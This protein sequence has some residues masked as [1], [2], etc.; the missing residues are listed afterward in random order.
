MA[1]SSARAASPK[2]WTNIGAP[3][4]VA[5]PMVDQS[6]LAFRLLARK[7]GA[8][9]A[10]TPMIHAGVSQ[11][12]QRGRGYLARHFQTGDGDWPLVAQ[13]A[14]ADEGEQI[15]RKGR[16]GAFLLED[17]VDAAAKVV[18]RLR[19]DYCDGTGRVVTCKVR[20]MP[21]DGPA[22][23]GTKERVARL[24][25]A[26][27]SAITVHGR[28]RLQNKQHSGACDWSAI[29]TLR[30][31]LPAD[32]VAIAN[33]GIGCRGDVDRVLDATGCDAA[34]SSEGLLENP[35]S[36]RQASTGRRVPRRATAAR[37]RYAA[38][39][40]ATARTSTTRAPTSSSSR[41]A[42]STR[43]PRSARRSR[44][45]RTS[46]ASPP[47]ST[48]STRGTRGDR[49][50]RHHAPGFDEAASWYWRHRAAVAAPRDPGV[51][52]ARRLRKLRKAQAKARSRT[53]KAR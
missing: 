9:L 29:A 27:A 46:R 26:G 34:M 31:S 20:L 25:D 41:T 49:E 1:A 17:D 36:S 35:R 14:G 43:F 23:R 50:C 42:A 12:P 47:S 30:A 6:G 5:A 24:V 2:W 19:K 45:P 33:G 7:Y 15:A 53:A 32:V 11:C 37:A 3:K 52:E 21:D 39:A 38:L 40:A 13:F 48:S 18:A 4:F 51:V 16:Y 28:T 8:E 22:L 44:R 10:F